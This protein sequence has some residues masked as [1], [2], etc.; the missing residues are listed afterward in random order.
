[1]SFMQQEIELGEWLEIETSHGT[2]IIPRDLV[3][4]L[5]DDIEL[6]AEL[7]ADYV[8][9]DRITAIAERKGYGARLSAPG[10]M[11]CTDWGVYDT[12]SEARDS[13]T[14]MYGDDND[15]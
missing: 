3:G 14:E 5:P 12:E 7:V 6:A 2:E 13:L 15:D 11:D 1:M 8:Q 10:Y 4:E 9:G